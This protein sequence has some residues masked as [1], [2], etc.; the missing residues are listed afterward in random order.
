MALYSLLLLPPSLLS[1]SFS[2]LSLFFSSTF[3][4]LSLTGEKNWRLKAF[5]QTLICFELAQYVNKEKKSDR[6]PLCQRLI[7]DFSN[8]CCVWI[9]LP[10]FQRMTLNS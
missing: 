5:T 10:I 2:F 1:L 3:P 4:E 6:L 8:F 7:S 9:S